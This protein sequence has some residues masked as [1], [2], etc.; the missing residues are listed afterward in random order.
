MTLKYVQ[1]QDY[2]QTLWLLGSNE[3]EE[4]KVAKE[5]M[6]EIGLII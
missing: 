1:G 4:L 2:Q 5:N 3:S 6:S